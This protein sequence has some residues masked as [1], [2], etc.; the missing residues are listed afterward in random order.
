MLTDE[1]K[2]KRKADR[3]GKKYVYPWVGFDLDKTLAVYDEFKGEDH[4]GAPIPKMVELVKQ[5]LAE[6]KLVVKIFTARASEQDPAKKVL[7]LDAIA[8]WTQEVFGVSL[9][10]TCI[11]DYGCVRIYDDRAVQIQ[12]NT[13]ELMTDV[14]WDEG[15]QKCLEDG[16]RNPEYGNN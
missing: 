12:E 1:E 6:R 4:I 11:K 9:P 10:V 8:R 3:L 2:E 5:Y 14:A 7:V 16:S 13:G 15:Y